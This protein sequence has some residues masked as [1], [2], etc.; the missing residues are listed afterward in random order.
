MAVSRRLRFE[1]FRR[2]DFACRYCG[3]RAPEV[4]LTVDHVIP[5]TL[6][7]VDDP[8]NLVTCCSACNAG[9]TSIAPDSPFV[10]DVAADAIRWRRAIEEAALDWADSR[11]QLDSWIEDVDEIW[12]EWR[13]GGKN[14]LPRPSDW[15]ES[16]ET[17]IKNGLNRPVFEH[18]I[19]VT[20]RK[21]KVINAEKWTYFCG[22][23]WTRI[24][25]LQD[26]AMALLR[27]EGD[28]QD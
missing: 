24:A 21:T 13:D 15:P 1:I 20:M 18:L 28:G 14:P 17:F 27:M 25:Q 9:K 16:I 11:L 23:C 2:D 6:G 12:G 3:G 19:G 22:C 4:A 7:G 10:A 8:S 5:K 26:E